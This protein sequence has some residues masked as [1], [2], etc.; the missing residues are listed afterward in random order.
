MLLARGEGAVQVD[1]VNGHATAE[2]VLQGKVR[3]EDKSG[4]EQAE[5]GAI[6]PLR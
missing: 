4:N 2:A 6:R 1:K 5:V 3:D